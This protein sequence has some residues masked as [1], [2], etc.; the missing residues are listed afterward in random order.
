MVHSF[1]P[2]LPCPTHSA[3]GGAVFWVWARARSVPGLG[4]PSPA[5]AG[6]VQR[7]LEPGAEE[8]DPCSASCGPGLPP[9]SLGPP[10]RASF[11]GGFA[12]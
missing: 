5:E 11:P 4:T 7:G 10:A 3:E 2:H 8:G 6:C 1:L 12:R 9:Q